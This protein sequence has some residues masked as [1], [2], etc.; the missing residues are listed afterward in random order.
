[1]S[2]TSPKAVENRSDLAGSALPIVEKTVAAAP[3]RPTLRRLGL[4]LVGMIA[5][6]GVMIAA[7]RL[8]SGLGGQPNDR[9]L[10]HVVEPGQ[11]LVTI[12]EDGQLESAQNT[13]L[14]CEIAGGSTILW[15]I[16][17]GTH[18]E[19]GQ[20]LVRLDSSKIDEEIS[21]QKIAYEKAVA[22]RVKAVSELA[23]AKAAKREYL[24]GTFV[25][26]RQTIESEVLVAAENVNRAQEYYQFSKRLASK[27][28]VND[29]QLNADRFAVEKS[30]KELDVANTKLKVLEEFTKAKMLQELQSKLDA[31]DGTLRSEIAALE[32]EQARLK[33]LESQREK[34]VIRA[35]TDG[36]AIYARGHRWWDQE[37]AIAEGTEVRENQTL[38][39]LP[40]LSQMQVKVSVHESKVDQVKRGMPARV[41]IQ[42]RE[43]T[44]RVT[45]IANQASQAGWWANNVK[46][47]ETVVKIDG[48]P[49]LKP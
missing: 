39:E 48:D 12:T 18:V 11:L 26:E 34:C 4:V 14:Q 6:G 32:L 29:L 24:E 47:F 43:F 37:P 3:S 20:E 42:E 28:Y 23:L 25:Q 49:G 44:G 9:L 17:D 21:K 16:E 35:A 13:E 10:T 31:A 40:D 5:R 2:V 1:M 27:G 15:I 8:S 46:K 36:M 38:I 33:R 19:E 45:S 7:Q 41:R 22:A 30:Q